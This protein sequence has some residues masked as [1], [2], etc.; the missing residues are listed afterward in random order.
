MIELF[1]GELLN[2]FIN[3]M[4]ETFLN[5]RYIENNLDL[6]IR[7]IERADI[8]YL[9]QRTENFIELEE[10]VKFHNWCLAEL[11]SRDLGFL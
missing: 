3:I 1:I 11:E 2:P 7:C 10:L 8:I 9:N 5:R 6:I 4:Y